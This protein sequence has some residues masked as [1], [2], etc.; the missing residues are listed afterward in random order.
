[1]A[2]SVLPDILEK[3]ESEV[4]AEWRKA[5]GGGHG[6]TG[7]LKEGELD[8]QTREVLKLLKDAVHGDNVDNIDAPEFAKLRELMRLG[9]KRLTIPTMASHDP[10]AQAVSQ[11]L[12]LE[13]VLPALR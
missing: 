7:R 5:L 3:H 9:L 6:K 1:M 13:E 10:A 12:L 4:L 2:K 8:T 11:R